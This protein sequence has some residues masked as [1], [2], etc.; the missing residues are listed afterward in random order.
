MMKRILASALILSAISGFGLVGCS[1]TAK[2]EVKV[3][4]KGPGGTT[5]E[6]Q[7]HEVSKSGQNPPAPGD[8]GTST[9]V[10]EETKP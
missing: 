3:E 6:S 2:E 9:A 8:P 7:T 10:K 5:T 4:T 1:D